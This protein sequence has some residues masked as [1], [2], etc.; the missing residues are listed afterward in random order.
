MQ[1]DGIRLQQ[2]D[3]IVVVKWNTVDTIRVVAT[4][5]TTRP[6]TLHLQVVMRNG[7]RRTATL[8]DKGHMQ[9]IGQ[10]DLG[11][12]ALDL[13]KMRVIVPLR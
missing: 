11:D 3:G 5:D 1:A 9:L 4:N 8:A 7:A 6:P 13:H 2:G 10:T 12:Y